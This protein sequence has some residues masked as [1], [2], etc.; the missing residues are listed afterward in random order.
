MVKRASQAKFS[1]VWHGRV[2]LW[3]LSPSLHLHQA[4]SSQV[5]RQVPCQACFCQLLSD[6]PVLCQ[7]LSQV[8]SSKFQF[9]SQKASLKYFVKQVLRQ[10]VL[11]L[12]KAW[13]DPTTPLFFPGACPSRRR[14]CV[15]SSFSTTKFHDFGLLGFLLIWSTKRGLLATTAT[16]RSSSL[17]SATK[18]YT[19]SFVSTGRLHH[20]L[21]HRV[22]T[23]H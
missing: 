4:W 2:K 8:W 16:C 13:L 7:V 14:P 23:L 20:P 9:C 18:L 6:K 3:V 17:S 1:L 22:S 12:S 11:K 10:Q 5:L 19:T 21:Y 15:S